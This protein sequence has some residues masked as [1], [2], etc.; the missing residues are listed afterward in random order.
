MALADPEDFFV[1]GASGCEFFEE[2]RGF[3]IDQDVAVFVAFAV[4]D[5]DFEF[6]EV[7]V[8][9]EDSS[10]LTD[11]HGA[12]VEGAKEK[13][14]ARLRFGNLEKLADFGAGQDGGQA[15]TVFVSLGQ[16]LA[17]K[18]FVPGFVDDAGPLPALLLFEDG[19]RGF[20]D[21]EGLS[22]RGLLSSGDVVGE[23]A[24]RLYAVREFGDVLELLGG[25]AFGDAE[26]GEGF[27]LMGEILA[28][29]R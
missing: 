14:V 29:H 7:E 2:S 10:D 25:E 21:L 4:A 6:L 19:G 23:E 28:T 11:S 26:G 12:G 8:G 13:M 18:L 1:E 20:H 22:E 17:C 15:V 3:G 16:E 24:E 5:E 9:D 27:A